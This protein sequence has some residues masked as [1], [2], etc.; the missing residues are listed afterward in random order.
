ME[1]A[2]VDEV[3]LVDQDAS[4][5][6]VKH[7]I[8]WNSS[9]VSK[10]S[11]MEVSRLLAEMMQHGLRCIAFCKT[12]KLCEPKLPLLCCGCG[13]GGVATRG[14]A[15]DEDH[16]QS[17]KVGSARQ[18]SWAQVEAMMAGFTL[19][20]VGEGGFS[21]VYLA[22]LAGSSQLAAVKV[23]VVAAAAAIVGPVATPVCGSGPSAVHQAA[24]APSPQDA[25]APSPAPSPP[26]ASAPSPPSLQLRPPRRRPLRRPASSSGPVAPKPPAAPSPSP[27]PTAPLPHPHQNKENKDFLQFPKC[28]PDNLEEMSIMYEN[29]NVTGESSM[30]SGC[31]HEVLDLE[32][33]EIEEIEL[34]PT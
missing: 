6:G 32:E 22:R 23:F 7:F 9:S 2:G 28:G 15:T 21:T 27:A 30:M 1:L 12:R 16:Q 34:Y 8:L 3:E 14:A 13:T 33:D 18:L 31:E 20:V 11:V 19:A 17:G 25:P 4:P 26:I 10:S 5:H 29:I 24:P